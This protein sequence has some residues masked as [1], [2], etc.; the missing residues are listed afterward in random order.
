M[1]FVD[2]VDKNEVFL[3]YKNFTIREL[4]ILPF[5]KGLTQDFGQKT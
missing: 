1:M 3:D 2:V 4:K 5:P